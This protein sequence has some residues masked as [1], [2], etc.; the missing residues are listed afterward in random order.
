MELLVG[1]VKGKV[2]PAEVIIRPSFSLISP[3]H[4]RSPSCWTT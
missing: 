2:R 1:D 3:H 4:H